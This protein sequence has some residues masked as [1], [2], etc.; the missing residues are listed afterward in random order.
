MEAL[1]LTQKVELIDKKEFAK[2]VFDENIKALMVYISFLSLRLRMIIHLAK[3][4]QIALL[5]AEKVI[6]PAKYLDFADVFLKELANIL[7]KQTGVNKHA[8]ELI[9]GK[10]QP[11]RPI[12]DLELVDFKAFKIY[13]ETNLPN[14]FIQAS[15]L[16]ASTSI[17][18]VNKLDG[19]FCLCV[20]C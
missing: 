6:I 12:Y 7:T 4:V 2:V 19:S 20:N 13:I 5:L 18:F 11:Y 1:P 8:I 15:K 10:Q 3:K 9:K 17:L 14:G 16:L